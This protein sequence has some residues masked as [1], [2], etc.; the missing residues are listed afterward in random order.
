MTFPRPVARR[1]GRALLAVLLVTSIAACSSD[2]GSE[3]G[4]DGSTTTEAPTVTT[5]DLGSDEVTTDDLG[6]DDLGS[7]DLG[8]DDV[9]T[10][11]AP[12]GED[13]QAYVD[14]LVATFEEDESDELYTEDQVTCLAEGFVDIIGVDALQSAGL[15]PQEFAE[16]GIDDVPDE[17][18][19]DDEKANAMYDTF[20]D[21]DIDLQE[22]FASTAGG[23]ELTADEQAC[24]DDLLTDDNLRASFV[25]SFTG[26]ELEDDPLDDAFECFDFGSAS[27]PVAEPV[28]PTTVG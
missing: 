1:A 26:D 4:G 13:E 21:C 18:G 7:D 15:S 14:A 10:D 22:L 25:A 11:D 8:S 5:D 3:G 20:A 2:D 16:D 24:L 9:T 28:T 27:G 23:E 12:V 17:L 19:V 6:S